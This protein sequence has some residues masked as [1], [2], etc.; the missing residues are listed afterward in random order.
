MSYDEKD[1][2]KNGE[3]SPEEKNYEVSTS[4]VKP[5]NRKNAVI[6][7]VPSKCQNKPSKEKT[8]SNGCCTIS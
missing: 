7:N 1:T 2:S 4:L 3:L 8:K 5:C 6:E